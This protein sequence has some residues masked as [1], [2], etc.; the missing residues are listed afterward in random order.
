LLEKYRLKDCEARSF[1]SFL[2]CML[3]WRPKDR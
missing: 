2:N 3:K 1:S